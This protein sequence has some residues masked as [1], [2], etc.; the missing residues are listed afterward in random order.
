MNTTWWPAFRAWRTRAAP[1]P[2]LPPVIR[3]RLGVMAFML[4]RASAGPADRKLEPRDPQAAPPRSRDAHRD[5]P[6]R[7]TGRASFR[8]RWDGAAV[9]RGRGARLRQQPARA[10]RLRR[11]QHGRAEPLHHAAVAA[12]GRDARAGAERGRGAPARQPVAGDQL[13]AGRPVAR[14]VPGVERRRADPLGA[15]AVRDRPPHADRRSA[16]T[17]RA[18]WRRPPPSR[19]SGSSTRCRPRWW[20]TSRSGPSR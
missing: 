19:C 14:R 11:R 10:L 1:I 20:T 17:R 7:A 18:R 12:L 13:R 16:T 15:R 3:K 8:D 4:L 9:D 2:W 6:A 5:R